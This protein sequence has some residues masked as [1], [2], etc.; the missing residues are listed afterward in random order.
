MSFLGM[1]NVTILEKVC[2]KIETFKKYDWV[3][4]AA[5]QKE[6]F[7]EEWLTSNTIW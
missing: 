2:L 4:C 6:A 7:L 5:V 1:E 3:S